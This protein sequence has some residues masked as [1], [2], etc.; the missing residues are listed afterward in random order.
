MVLDEKDLVQDGQLRNY[1]NMANSSPYGMN[2]AMQNTLAGFKPFLD[3]ILQL[4]PKCDNK[5]KRRANLK[6]HAK[7]YRKYA[8]FTDKERLGKEYKSRVCIIRSCLHVM[9]LV[10]SKRC[11]HGEMLYMAKMNHILISIKKHNCVSMEAMLCIAC[12][13]FWHLCICNFILTQRFLF[14]S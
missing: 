12:S 8:R 13:S 9:Q 4:I 6:T 5:S 10:R 7:I 1:Q 11:A 3:K 2:R 14:L